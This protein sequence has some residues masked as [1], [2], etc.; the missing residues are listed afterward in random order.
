[1]KH[2]D[3]YNMK[4]IDLSVKCCFHWNNLDMFYDR[5]SVLLEDSGMNRVNLCHY[6]THPSIDEMDIIFNSWLKYDK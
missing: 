5:P 4:D 3:L 2:T 1:M 6:P